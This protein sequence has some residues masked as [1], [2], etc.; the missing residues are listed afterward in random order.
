MA[1]PCPR[2]WPIL[3]ARNRYTFSLP[4]LPKS[5]AIFLVTCPEESLRLAARRDGETCF[6][7]WRNLIYQVAASAKLH[8]SEDRSDVTLFFFFCFSCPPSL[9]PSLLMERLQN[10]TSSYCQDEQYRFAGWRLSDHF[11]LWSHL[12]KV[13]FQ[14]ADQKPKCLI[15]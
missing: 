4:C 9:L 11:G 3:L 2:P 12:K 13:K 10:L 6:S 14:M 15:A 8:G 5:P 7:S 1:T